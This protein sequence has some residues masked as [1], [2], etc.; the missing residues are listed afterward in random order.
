M[1][2]VNCWKIVVS[3]GLTSREQ[4]Q[5]TCSTRHVRVL[6]VT[7]RPVS[8]ESRSQFKLRF[9]LGVSSLHVIFENRTVEST[10]T[11]T[12]L[13]HARAFRECDSDLL[14]IIHVQVVH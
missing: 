6:P 12:H 5:I 4:A 3:I 11:K 8:T 1:L 14:Y 9:N 10:S 2:L 7:W 13:I